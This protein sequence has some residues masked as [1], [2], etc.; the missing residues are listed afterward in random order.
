MDIRS[1]FGGDLLQGRKDPLSLVAEK[2]G[3]MACSLCKILES[4]GCGNTRIR[5]KR[6]QQACNLCLRQANQHSVP[7]KHV[8]RRQTHRNVVSKNQDEQGNLHSRND[9]RDLHHDP[10]RGDE[11]APKDARSLLA[12]RLDRVV[13]QV[14]FLVPV[15][16]VVNGVS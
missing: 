1:R 10:A 12:L 3:V 16:E 8:S 13:E 2:L 5:D 11:W 15:G 7:S 6:K 4:T 9:D 14:R